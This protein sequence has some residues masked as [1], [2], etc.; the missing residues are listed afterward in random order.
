M[1]VISSG[2]GC[3]LTKL[4][5]EPVC[6]PA[7]SPCFFGLA[8]SCDLAAAA[9]GTGFASFLSNETSASAGFPM[10]SFSSPLELVPGSSGLSNAMEKQVRGASLD[11]TSHDSQ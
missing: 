6:L 7:D 3:T 2:N 1:A 11:A 5:D 10:A 9:A 8:L 4:E